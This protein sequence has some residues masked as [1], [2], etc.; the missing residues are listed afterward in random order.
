VPRGGLRRQHLVRAHR[1]HAAP[2][3]GCDGGDR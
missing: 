2:A 3:A 1:H